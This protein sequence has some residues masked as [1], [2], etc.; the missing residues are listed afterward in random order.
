[1]SEEKPKSTLVKVTWAVA[2][3]FLAGFGGWLFTLAR[4]GVELVVN[5]PALSV[6]MIPEED[7]LS[8]LALVTSALV[9]DPAHSISDVPSDRFDSFGWRSVTYDWSNVAAA[10]HTVRLEFRT[11]QERPVVIERIEP[12]ILSRNDPIAGWFIGNGGCGSLPIRTGVLNLDED[13]PRVQIYDA[14]NTKIDALTVTA[15]D[16][17][18]VEVFA[19]TRRWL[20]EWTLDIH[21]STS[22]GP[23]VISI[24]NDGSPFRLSTEVGSEGYSVEWGNRSFSREPN[25]DDGIDM[26]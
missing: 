4:S 22:S 13:I 21:Y 23:S 24:D 10:V 14:D 8:D 25:W 2:A 26:C 16:V 3:A 9:S 12:R 6:R 5:G 11:E 7:F 18:I 15:S 20:V 17:E 1:M 19:H